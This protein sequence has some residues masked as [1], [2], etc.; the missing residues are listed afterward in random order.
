LRQ[1]SAPQAAQVTGGRWGIG[2]AQLGQYLTPV[3]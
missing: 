1:C 2:A 3:R